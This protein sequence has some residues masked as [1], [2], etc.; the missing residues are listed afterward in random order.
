M[1]AKQECKSKSKSKS[2]AGQDRMGGP[3]I[4]TISNMVKTVMER[5]EKF[6]MLLN[7]GQLLLSS[8][9]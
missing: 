9:A 6:R 3:K 1:I 8:S 7:C 4:R 2:K 5:V